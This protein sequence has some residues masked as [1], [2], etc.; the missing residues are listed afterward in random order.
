MHQFLE[1]LM[2]SIQCSFGEFYKGPIVAFTFF[3]VFCIE[4]MGVKALGFS[5][6]YGCVALENSLVTQLFELGIG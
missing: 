6:L 5:G 3:F 2:D 1:C 4:N